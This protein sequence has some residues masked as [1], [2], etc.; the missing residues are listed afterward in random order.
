VTE[1]I[2]QATASGVSAAI[3]A[4]G[5]A[6]RMG[7]QDKGLLQVGGRP[8]VSYVIGALRPQADELLINANRHLATYEELCTCRVIP[9]SLEGFAGPL[10]GMAVAL[11]H[12]AHDL[13]LVVPCDAPLIGPDLAERLAGP[14][15]ADRA[16]IAVASDGQRMQP[17]FAL[18]RRSLLDSL[19]EYLARG[20]RKIDRWYAEHR[21]EEVTFSRQ[22]EMF[23]NI[24]TPED[25]RDVEQQLRRSA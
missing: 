8:M 7:G 3:L 18:L 5:R 19:R 22:P 20:G 2:R 13:L 24:N 15:R 11:E 10:A 6:R 21:V 14:A 4:G 25:I 23:T 1:T 9:D 16:D 12:A 17:V